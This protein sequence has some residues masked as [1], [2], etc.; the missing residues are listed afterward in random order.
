LESTKKSIKEK[1]FDGKLFIKKF[2]Q[3][4]NQLKIVLNVEKFKIKILSNP[5]KIQILKYNHN[6]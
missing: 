3:N 5:S 4:K 2:Q 1:K 6:N